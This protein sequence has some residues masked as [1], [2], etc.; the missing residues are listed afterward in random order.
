MPGIEL[1]GQCSPCLYSFESTLAGNT[2]LPYCDDLDLDVLVANPVNDCPLDVRIEVSIGTN[3]DG[4]YSELQNFDLL[5][6]NAQAVGEDTWVGGA[7]SYR[8]FKFDYEVPANDYSTALFLFDFVA[9]T[10]NSVY[11]FYK[12]HVLVYPIDEECE[13]GG[14]DT[15]DLHE[16]EIAHNLTHRAI[17]GKVSDLF[18]SEDLNDNSCSGT[19]FDRRIIYGTL[20]VDEDYCFVKPGA[21][22]VRQPVYLLPDARILVKPG[23]TLTL[24]HVDIFTCD[25]LAEGIVAE[26]GGKV[27]AE[28]VK[29]MD[30]RHAVSAQPNAS[31]DLRDCE[32]TNNYI[33]LHLD[34]TGASAGLERVTFLGFS[35]N[36]FSTGSGQT[37]KDPYPGMP[38]SVED[39][40]YC[41]IFLKNYRD[42]NVF[43][44][45]DFL[46]LS[47]G[48]V[49]ASSTMN[50]GNLTFTDMKRAGTANGYPL[51]GFGIH[52]S[53]R[54]NSSWANV[55]IPTAPMSF[56]DCKTGIFAERYAGKVEHCAMTDVII[57]ID[58]QRSQT[59]DV[60]IR[61][62]E[63]AAERYGIR[64]FLNEPTHPVSGIKTNTIGIA[65]GNNGTVPSVGIRLDEAQLGTGF[66]GGWPVSVNEITLDKGGN[67]IRYTNGWAGRLDDNTIGNDDAAE[68]YRGILI[69]QMAHGSV[70]G[71]TVSQVVSDDNYGPS[72]GIYA[73]GGWADAFVCNCVDNTDVG[74]QFYSMAEFT[75]AVR[76]NSFH[77]HSVG[78]R[79]GDE[80]QPGIYIGVQVDQ[81]N[82]WTLPVPDGD[83]GGV[84][85]NLDGLF[86]SEFI[87]DEAE[88]AAFNPPVDPGNGWFDDIPSPGKA[89]FYCSDACSFTDP[90]PTHEGETDTP[91]GLDEAIVDNTL[92]GGAFPTTTLWMGE[93]RLYRK[94]LRI[95]ALE[96]VA[97]KYAT[98]KSSRST[99]PVGKLGYIAQERAKLYNLTSGQRTTL[100]GYRD[101]LLKK[102]KDI[103][104]LD[105]L[106]Q[107][108]SAINETNY[109]TLVSQRNTAAGQL[110]SFYY[111]LDTARINKINVLLTLNAAVVDTILPATN[112]KDYNDI[113]L[114]L[115]K[116]DTL[117]TG[118]LA[119]LEG[120]AK[121]CPEEGG[122]AVYE[123]RAIFGHFTGEAFDDYE[124]C[125]EAQERRAQ[126]D[127]K[128]ALASADRIYPNPTTGLVQWNE[129]AG[130]VS[131]VEVYNHLGQLQM[132]QLPVANSANLSGLPEG[133]Y[134]IR[135]FREGQAPLTHSVF[136]IE[137]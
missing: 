52:L 123:A 36:T 78:L 129:N 98:F 128:K 53:T 45:N 5:S 28:E 126:P 108:G 109:A 103:R 50:L 33:G 110:E 60:R 133:A 38:E 39:R 118:D 91:T 59:R 54:N 134:W 46:R 48:I 18:L 92:P 76:G 6:T 101:T 81:G 16:V 93:Y 24:S 106:R 85:W 114:R 58:W 69:E 37:L 125:S 9:E 62:N 13:P 97:A 137:K 75:N 127:E 84:N 96:S 135:L 88:N 49:G 73:A 66:E 99:R 136:L 111:S 90:L 107:A 112:Q 77:D 79:L 19:S 22:S 116:T 122:D 117:A 31:L 102:V 34:M 63:I 80:A 2:L 1:S 57:G 15:P 8:R 61:D 68:H 131:S 44:D 83:W 104:Q 25:Q 27:I 32:F 20:E 42:F 100:S 86:L 121:Q 119:A 29:F 120:I 23:K 30:A 115:L 132:K 7:T 4:G 94:L 67:G 130:A 41:G 26:P 43:G 21:T 17:T 72:A 113:L 47:N 65:A 14:W 70:V 35:D 12:V 56:E 64:S 82:Q 40:G 124:L 105:S 3:T 55:G 10:H 51:E 87:V 74:I 95:P 89:S 11:G 71:N